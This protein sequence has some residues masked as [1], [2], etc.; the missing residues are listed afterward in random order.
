MADVAKEMMD[1]FKDQ[2]GLLVIEGLVNQFKPQ[3]QGMQEH[4]SK[5]LGNNEKTYILRQT[6]DKHAPIVF[7]VDNSKTLTLINNPDESSLITEE[8][9]KNA[10]GKQIFFAEP[11]AIKQIYKVD[12]FLES[13]LKG[14]F[15]KK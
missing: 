12:E 9:K 7:I 2:A 3:L 1:E 14:Q 10:K 8:A 5:D 15:G 6:S 13:L 4:I 11:D